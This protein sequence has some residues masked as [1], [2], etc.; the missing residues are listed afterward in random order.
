MDTVKNKSRAVTIR[1]SSDNGAVQSAG[2]AQPAPRAGYRKRACSHAVLSVVESSSGDIS[3]DEKYR[4]NSQDL[5]VEVVQGCTKRG[6]L[7]EREKVAS[8]N[9]D[10]QDIR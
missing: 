6:R 7:S 4:S 3:R 5:R 10:A 8:V 2:I 9:S 1:N